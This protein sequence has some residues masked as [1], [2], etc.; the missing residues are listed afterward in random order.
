[1]D[2]RQRAHA[3]RSPP[4]T[5]RSTPASSPAGDVLAS[6][7]D[8]VG[9]Y[10]VPLHDPPGDDRRGRRAAR[11][12]RPAAG[13]GRAGRQARSSSTAAPPTRRAG[14]DPARRRRRRL[15]DRRDARHPAPDGTWSDR[16]SRPRRPATTAPLSGADASETRRL[17]VIDRQRRRARDQDAASRVTVTPA[18]P[19]APRRAPARPARALRLVAGRSARAWTTSRRPTSASARPARV[20]V[21]LVDKDGW[22]PLATSPVVVVPRRSVRNEVGAKLKSGTDA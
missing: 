20:R 16:A 21:V 6:Q 15:H 11:D 14:R 10:A 8:D 19:Y 4:T 3:T 7:F 13:R 9:A 5:A 17:L 22:T 2:Q 12:P 18:L 1:M